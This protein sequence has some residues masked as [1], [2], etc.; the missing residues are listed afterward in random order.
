MQV[1]TLKQAPFSFS[2][3]SISSTAPFSLTSIKCIVNANFFLNLDKEQLN[4]QRVTVYLNTH[5]LPNSEP[6]SMYK[7]YFICNC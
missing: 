2:F 3:D 7:Q 4:L 5:T 1:Q 6:A